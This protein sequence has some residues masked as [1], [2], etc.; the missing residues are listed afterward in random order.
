MQPWESPVDRA[1]REAQER[2]EFDNLPGQGRPLPPI[3]P[4][5]ADW[6]VRALAQ[7]EQLDFTGALP[8]ALALRKEAA[9]FP[10]SLADLAS[11][12]SVRAVL[13]DFNDRVR[14]DRL[15]PAEGPLPPMLAPT[16]DVE[17]V[18]RRWRTMRES[19]S[20]GA[21]MP[22]RPVSSTAHRPGGQ[23]KPVERPGVIRRWWQQRRGRIAR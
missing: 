4:H 12:E 8:P 20:A 19:A 9:A 1:I 23:G 5:D 22:H 11:E 17:E 7:R 10:E 15:R 6:F 13:E 2:G 18:L 16:V 21:G 14:R 3:N